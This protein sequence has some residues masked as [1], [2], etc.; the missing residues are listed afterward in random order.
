MDVKTTFHHGD[1][2]ERIFMH[3]SQGLV[4]EG[5]QRKVCLLKKSMYGLKQSLI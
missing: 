2:E 5:Q 4:Q 1:L 3:Q